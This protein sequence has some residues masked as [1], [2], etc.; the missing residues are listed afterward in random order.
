MREDCRQC[1]YSYECELCQRW[2]DNILSN[3]VFITSFTAIFPIRTE[4]APLHASRAYIPCT[5]AGCGY[6]RVRTPPGAA[7][8]T[9]LGSDSSR[10]SCCLLRCPCW[11][12]EC[13]AQVWHIECVAARHHRHA[14]DHVPSIS[15]ATSDNQQDTEM[16]QASNGGQGQVPCLLQ[17]VDD[18]LGTDQEYT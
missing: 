18:L 14:A 11:H 17:E 5:G 1:D 10:D 2:T 7:Q 9:S 3:A 8:A 6:A 4:A 13:D 16:V 12:I 15:G